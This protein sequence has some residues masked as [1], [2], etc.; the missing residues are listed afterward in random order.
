MCRDE[1]GLPLFKV[2]RDNAQ[3]VEIQN[4]RCY[5]GGSYMCFWKST[6]G[7]PDSCWGIDQ[8]EVSGEK[9][10]ELSL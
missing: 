1:W 3:L 10:F 6:R 5:I 9:M 4:D 2:P 8:G 7:A